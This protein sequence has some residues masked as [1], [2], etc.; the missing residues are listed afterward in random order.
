MQR[1]D[2]FFQQLTGACLP[3]YGWQ[4]ELAIASRV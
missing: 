2:H 1:F 3:P 4:A